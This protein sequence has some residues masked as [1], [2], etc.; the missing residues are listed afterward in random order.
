MARKR[1]KPADEM[2]PSPVAAKLLGEVTQPPTAV[3]QVAQ[4]PAAPQPRAEPAPKSQEEA[5]PKKQ[6]KP[7]R[8]KPATSSLAKTYEA[9]VMMSPD[10]R[11]AA[12]D[13]VAALQDATGTEVTQS[14]VVRALL[15]LASRATSAIKANAEH[16]E[17]PPR[18]AN[19]DW[20][21]LAAYEDAIA[22]Y[23]LIALRD[24]LHMDTDE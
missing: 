7:R 15:T 13:A 24:K 11:K 14:H 22:D 2:P 12:K 9:R 5:N 21:Q 19:N 1:E 18:P 20:Q 16:V 6:A 4:E 8:R 10:E 3:T 23:L 17:I